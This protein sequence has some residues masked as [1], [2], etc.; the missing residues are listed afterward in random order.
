MLFARIEC[1]RNFYLL[2]TVG[3]DTDG[4]TFAYNGKR[5]IGWDSAENVRRKVNTYQFSAG[6]GVINKF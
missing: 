1:R 5:W 4:N 6:A 2:R 3:K